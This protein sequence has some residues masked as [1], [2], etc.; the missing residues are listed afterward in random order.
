MAKKGSAFNVI[1]WSNRHSKK[2]MNSTSSAPIKKT[3][4]ALTQESPEKNE[5]NAKEKWAKSKKK[6]TGVKS[7]KYMQSVPNFDLVGLLKKVKIGHLL[8]GN[9]SKTTHKVGKNKICLENTCAPDSI[10][11]LIAVTYA[12]NPT[13]KNYLNGLDDPIYAIAKLLAKK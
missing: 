10:I 6:T 9:L 5:L 7:S 11:Q 4:K 8:N 1:P 2:K 12:Y 13:Y 3:Q